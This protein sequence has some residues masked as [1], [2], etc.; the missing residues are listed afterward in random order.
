MTG[1]ELDA[2]GS[3]AALGTMDDKPKVA[4]AAT[5]NALFTISSGQISTL[6]HVN[7]GHTPNPNAAAD[8]SEH[9]EMV[10]SDSIVAIPPLAPEVHDSSVSASLISSSSQNDGIS[11]ESAS[12]S[13][14]VFF[15][16]RIHSSHKTNFYTVVI[17]L[18]TI[19]NILKRRFSKVVLKISRQ[20][21]WMPC[22]L[23]PLFCTWMNLL[24][25]TG[26]P[27]TI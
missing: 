2:L 10:A 9:L 17:T 15:K 14:I 23:T 25:R 24:G 12:V 6:G 26:V 27:S 11:T 7:G 4:E 19:L 8:N 18:L 13:D 3:S 21:H 1:A 20:N 5:E 16:N 22:L